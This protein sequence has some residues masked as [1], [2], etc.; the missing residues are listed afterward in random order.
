MSPWKAMA[1]AT[2]LLLAA[3]VPTEAEPSPTPSARNSTVPRTAS[4][5]ATA[6]ASSTPEAVAPAPVTVAAADDALAGDVLLL[7]QGLVLVGSLRGTPAIWTSSDGDTWQIQAEGALG[8]AGHLA[9]LTELDGLILA[10]GWRSIRVDG[11]I[12]NEPLV[13]VG[14]QSG[15][16]RAVSDLP[17]PANVGAQL[18]GIAR[19][20]G[21]VAVGGVLSDGSLA[22]WVTTDDGATWAGPNVLP[23]E[24]GSSISA[25][26]SSRGEFVAVGEAL[27]RTSGPGVWRSIDGVEWIADHPVTRGGSL[28]DVAAMEGGAVAVGHDGQGQATVWSLDASPPAPVEPP[29]VDDLYAIA[30]SGSS[31]LVAAPNAPSTPV[32]LLTQSGWSPLRLAGAGTTTLRA[33]SAVNG[34]FVV[35]GDDGSGVMVWRGRFD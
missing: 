25:M 11:G 14:D 35:A 17:L 22:A 30:P 20:G 24:P 19:D 23:S 16:W 1:S 18:S 21:R 26:V 27:G 15:A 6:E 8:Q 34:Q 12:A 3:C 5:L 13:V 28:A 7:P 33:M 10:V 32:H 31:F 9:E 4:P 2:L 29:D